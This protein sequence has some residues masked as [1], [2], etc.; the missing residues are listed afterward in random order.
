MKNE[1]GVTFVLAGSI[2][3]FATLVNTFPCGYEGMTD[4]KVVALAVFNEEV[5]ECHIADGEYRC[6]PITFNAAHGSG[7]SY[8]L[9]ALDLI[10]NCTAKQAVK[11]A[12]KKDCATGGRIRTVK[13]R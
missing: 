13:V 3:D 4:L 8:A 5:V 12:M 9:A 11:Y 2:A 7:G 1:V 10:P 6:T